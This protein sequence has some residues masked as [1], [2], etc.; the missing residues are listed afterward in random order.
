MHVLN[1]TFSSLLEMDEPD[2]IDIKEL[3][4]QLQLGLGIVM[5]LILIAGPSCF[6]VGI[7]DLMGQYLRNNHSEAMIM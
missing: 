3:V 2:Y 6:L 4:W 5:A 1:P 7:K